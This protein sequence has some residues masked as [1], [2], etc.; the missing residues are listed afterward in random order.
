MKISCFVIY[1]SFSSSPEVLFEN[2]PY[3]IA[4]STFI[5]INVVLSVLIFGFA[6]SEIFGRGTLKHHYGEVVSGI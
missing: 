5:S 4:E 2:T 1:L 6:L 3:I